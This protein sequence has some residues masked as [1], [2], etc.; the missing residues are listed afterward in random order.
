MSRIFGCGQK[1]N[2]NNF[3]VEIPYLLDNLTKCLYEIKII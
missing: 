3:N 2:E 1:K